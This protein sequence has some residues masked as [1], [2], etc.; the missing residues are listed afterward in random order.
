[1]KQHIVKLLARG[2][3]F[4]ARVPLA[5]CESL[6]RTGDCTACFL[7]KL[8]TNVTYGQEASTDFLACFARPRFCSSS[9]APNHHK[10]FS[11]H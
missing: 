9:H 8:V 5:P 10:Y 2:P 3:A 1:M 11:H 7:V 4:P 6:L